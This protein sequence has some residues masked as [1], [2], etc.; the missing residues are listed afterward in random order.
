MFESR[1]APR[2]AACAPVSI[3][4]TCRRRFRRR[5]SASA[6]A[7]MPLFIWATRHCAPPREKARLVMLHNCQDVDGEPMPALMLPGRSVPMVFRTMSAALDAQRRAEGW[8]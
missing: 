3:C 5:K 2:G 6:P 8:A 1:R 4:P 7:P